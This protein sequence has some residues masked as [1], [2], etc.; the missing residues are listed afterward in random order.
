M[1]PNLK[2]T[3]GGCGK[4][5]FFFIGGIPGL[6]ALLLTIVVGIYIFLWALGAMLIIADPIHPADAIALLSGGGADRMGEAVQLFKDRFADT[7]ILTDPVNGIRDT[8]DETE[9]AILRVEDARKMGVPAN[10]IIV[11]PTH[12]NSTLGEAQELRAFLEQH[13]IHSCIVVTDPYHTLRTRMI[14]HKVFQGSSIQVMV[15]PVRAHWYQSQSWMFS[16]RGLKA[17]TTEYL[18]I[19]AFLAGIPPVQ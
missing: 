3:P 14:L 4:G 16:K 5:C 13:S 7:L 2:R 10:K 15:R 9:S 1:D 11:T 18:K 17:T 12:P 6:F 8:G 19:A